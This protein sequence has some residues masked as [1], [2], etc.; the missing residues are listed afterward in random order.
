MRPNLVRDAGLGVGVEDAG[1]GRGRADGHGAL[2]DDDLAA[3]ADVGDESSARLDV[4]Q[5]GGSAL[6]V[7]E[8]FR[9]R[10][11]RDEHH[12]RLVHRLGLK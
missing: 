10:V 3:V 8:R 12:V 1:D 2:F 5:V 4:F 9:R 7:A 6:A 11:H